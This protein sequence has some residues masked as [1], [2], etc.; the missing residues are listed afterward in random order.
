MRSFKLNISKDRVKRKNFL[1]SHRLT[2][3][4]LKNLIDANPKALEHFLEK[5]EL[6]ENY[7]KE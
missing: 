1:I 6:K 5:K 7:W 2:Y 4:L 3:N